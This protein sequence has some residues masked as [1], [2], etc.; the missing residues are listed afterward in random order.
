MPDGVSFSFPEEI[1][2][3]RQEF[4]ELFGTFYESGENEGGLKEYL[5]S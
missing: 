5:K 3:R 1:E 2:A 4:P